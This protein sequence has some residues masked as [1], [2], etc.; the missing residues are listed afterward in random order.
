M[1]LRMKSD[2]IN[3]YLHAIRINWDS[4]R[5]PGYIAILLSRCGEDFV[6][7]FHYECDW[8]FFPRASGNSKQAISRK[9]TV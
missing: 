7:I 9:V 1:L 2:A 6:V 3:N 8:P 5:K 4:P